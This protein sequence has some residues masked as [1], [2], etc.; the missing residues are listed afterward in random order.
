MLQQGPTGPECVELWPYIP[1]LIRLGQVRWMSWKGWRVELRV[2]ARK[3]TD[4]VT[5][6]KHTEMPQM[7][8][9]HG[10]SALAFSASCCQVSKVHQ[11]VMNENRTSVVLS[12][13][14]QPMW[15]LR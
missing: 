4:L 12:C 13:T 2:K 10:D 8:E 11:Q 15:L 1:E 3:N 5:L 6:C 9:K 14:K 7:S